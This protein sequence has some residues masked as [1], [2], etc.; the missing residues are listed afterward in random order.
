MFRKTYYFSANRDCFISTVINRTSK[1]ITY[2][3]THSVAVCKYTL[4]FFPHKF[5]IVDIFFIIVIKADLLFISIIFKF[6]Y[7][8]AYK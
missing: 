2:V 7:I 3:Y 1:L 8:Q 6:L 5:Q 4:A